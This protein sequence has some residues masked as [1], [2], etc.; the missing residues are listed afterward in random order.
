[1]TAFTSGPMNHVGH[2]PSPEHPTIDEALGWE[3]HVNIPPS[4]LLTN[5]LRNWA[6]LQTGLAFSMVF[7]V[8]VFVGGALCV[9]LGHGKKNS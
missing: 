3:G 4:P 7:V 1:M 9:A 6:D 5:L 8:G 2:H